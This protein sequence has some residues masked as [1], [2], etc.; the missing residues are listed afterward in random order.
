[1]D[2]CK[3]DIDHLSIITLTNSSKSSTPSPSLSTLLTSSSTSSCDRQLPRWGD[4]KL[5][6][7]LYENIWRSPDNGRSKQSQILI[8]GIISVSDFDVNL[9]CL[10]RQATMSEW[11][12]VGLFIVT[13]VRHQEY[14]LGSVNRTAP[15]LV[16]RSES[17]PEFETKTWLK[18]DSRSL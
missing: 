18:S 8:E 1:M 17:Q 15:V 6:S 16:Q 13:N 5:A 2:Y 9:I 10:S 14:K 7:R 3:I 4:I 11:K 12:V